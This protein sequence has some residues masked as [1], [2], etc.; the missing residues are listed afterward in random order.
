[1]TGTEVDAANSARASRLSALSVQGLASL[2][3]EDVPQGDVERGIAARLRAAAAVAQIPVQGP[4]VPLDVQGVGPEQQGHR[5][6]VNVGFHRLRAEE[7]F[8]Q[9][10]QAGVGVQ[11]HEEQIGV[12]TETDRLDHGDL[13]ATLSV[14]RPVR[15]PRSAAPAV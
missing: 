10:G 2:L 11:S 12:L 9:P 1:V 8:A 4:G 6:L 15:S 5:R 3:A 7:G 14:C 13:H